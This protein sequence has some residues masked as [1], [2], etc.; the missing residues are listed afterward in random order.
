MTIRH[1]PRHHLTDWSFLE[2]LTFSISV[3][4]YVSF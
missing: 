2:V 4:T 1:L 3:D